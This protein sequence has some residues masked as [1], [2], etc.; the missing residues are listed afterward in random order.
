MVQ[1]VVEEV[2]PI[3]SEVNVISITKIKFKIIAKA[4]MCDG[5]VPL[6]SSL[7]LHSPHPVKDDNQVFD[8]TDVE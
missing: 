2:K 5:F 8:D 4:I 7:L 3:C 1:S 6:I